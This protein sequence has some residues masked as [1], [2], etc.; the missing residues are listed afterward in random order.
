MCPKWVPQSKLLDNARYLQKYARY[1][2]LSSAP[3]YGPIPACPS[4]PKEWSPEQT[5]R[6]RCGGMTYG[7]NRL[8]VVRALIA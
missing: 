2:L 3:N 1:V 6:T 5:S 7:L 8:D 4:T